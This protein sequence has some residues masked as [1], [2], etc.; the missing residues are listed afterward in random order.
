MKTKRLISLILL[1][2]ICFIITT[3]CASVPKKDMNSHERTRKH[4]NITLET[5]MRIIELEIRV[6]ALEVAL[7]AIRDSMPTAYEDPEAETAWKHYVG[8]GMETN[9]EEAAR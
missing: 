9:G 5:D 2:I 1:L 4:T 7:K 6:T 8:F 3:Q